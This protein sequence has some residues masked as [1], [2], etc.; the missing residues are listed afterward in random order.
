MMHLF[1]L[2]ERADLRQKG[3]RSNA[4]PAHPTGQDAA[5][6]ADGRFRLEEQLG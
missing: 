5:A 4:P 1:T 3:R 2:P 6:D